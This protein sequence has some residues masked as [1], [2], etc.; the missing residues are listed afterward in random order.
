[1]KGTTPGSRR[2]VPKNYPLQDPPLY[3]ASKARVHSPHWLP[4]WPLLRPEEAHAYWVC[5]QSVAAHRWLAMPNRR[6]KKGSLG[7]LF[8]DAR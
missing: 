5:G 8:V 6:K 2:I 1:M 7:C 4:D 3:A